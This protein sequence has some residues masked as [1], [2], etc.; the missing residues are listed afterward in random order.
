V[1]LE[2]AGEVRLRGQKPQL[3]ATSPLDR[4]GWAVGESP[5]CQGKAFLQGHCLTLHSCFSKTRF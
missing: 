4:N 5:V 1:L 2:L 3:K